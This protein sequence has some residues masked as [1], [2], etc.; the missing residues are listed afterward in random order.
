MTNG[1]CTF[2]SYEIESKSEFIASMKDIAS[3]LSHEKNDE[4]IEQY[5]DESK[6]KIEDKLVDYEK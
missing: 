5:M 3:I 1:Q 2:V 6:I 4:S